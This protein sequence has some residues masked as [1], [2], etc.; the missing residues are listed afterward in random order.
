MG[1]TNT[2]QK[3]QTLSELAE[4][5]YNQVQDLQQRITSLETAVDDTHETVTEVDQ[6]LAEQ[7]EL[8]LA[9]AE[10]HDLD[11]EAILEESTSADDP[12]VRDS[13]E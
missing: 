9:L 2:A 11:G 8:L 1:L 5:L 3:L 4:T 13:D 7:R 6:Q 10:E 12:N